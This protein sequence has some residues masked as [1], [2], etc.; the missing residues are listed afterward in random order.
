MAKTLTLNSPPPPDGEAP[1][2]RSLV[3]YQFT[4]L[5]LTFLSYAAFHASRKPPSI[6]KS[7]LSAHPPF[8]G[9][10]GPH[11]LGE[12][13]L[14]F[15]S[16]YSISMFF[17]GQMADR[18]DLRKFL[19]LGMLLSGAS[20]AAFGLGYWF[21][22]RHLS[23]YVLI[24]VFSGVVQ[25]VGWPCVVAIVGNWFG[26]SPQKG[27]IM[28]IWNSHTSAG[29][30]IGSVLAS[31]ILEFGWGWSFLLPALL[32]TIMGFFVWILLVVHP[33]DVGFD[34][35]ATEIEM[36]DEENI[37]GAENLNTN[38]ANGDGEEA[39]LLGI[40]GVKAEF[41]SGSGSNSTLAQTEAIGFLDAW[42]LPGVAPFAC[43]LF[44]S[45]LVAYTF[46]YWLPFYI[47][48]NGVSGQ[49]LSHKAAG[50]LSTIFDI[51]GVFGGISAG[52]ISDRLSGR[53]ITSILFLF[54]S[55][56]S[57]IIY[58]AYGDISM[59][60][61]IVLMFLSGY[62]VNGPYSLITTAVAS[63]LGT[64]ESIKG[65]ARALAT[66]TAI[67]D[68][69]GSVG[70]ALGPLLTGYISTRGWNS[71]FL[72]LILSISF[73]ILFLIKIAKAEIISKMGEAR[74]TVHV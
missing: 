49:Q 62:F 19:S 74:L 40:D 72:M 31:S 4:V 7:V 1:P 51:G 33:S 18:T 71:V 67:I 42:R 64:Q 30:I 66:V 54:L 21:D 43:C 44:F 14:A 23:F 58:R 60:H 57:L 34:T 12:L 45:K 26:K 46:L 73:A 2:R 13:D 15:L 37:A 38:R 29:N 3:R 48:H 10:S 59:K 55:I 47:R 36:D 5:L 41:D 65:N 16:V 11:R 28:G 69:T 32:I 61:N 8:D 39:T 22:I 9:P 68:G 24:Q 6:V 70:A 25:S 52:L 17:S 56:P 63:D 53:A 50:I 35:P 27:A 20:T